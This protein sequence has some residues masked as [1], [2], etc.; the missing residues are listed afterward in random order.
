MGIEED[1]SEKDE[2]K[3]NEDH[4]TVYEEVTFHECP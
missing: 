2:E 3:E 4:R 1:K